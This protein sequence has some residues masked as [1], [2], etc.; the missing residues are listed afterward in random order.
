MLDR[1]IYADG[2]EELVEGDNIAEANEQGRGLYDQPVRRVVVETSDEY[3]GEE[4]EEEDDENPAE[5]DDS[6]EEGV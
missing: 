4:D 2:R 5:D 3:D 1:V 6:A